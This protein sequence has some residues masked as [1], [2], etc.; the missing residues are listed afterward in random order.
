MPFSV[1][2]NVW[3]SG[4]RKLV[5]EKSPTSVLF[6]PNIKFHSFGFDA[7][8]KYAELAFDGKANDWYF[9]S[10]FK[11][12]LYNTKTIKRSFEIVADNG[13]MLPAMT[14]FSSCIKYLVN[15][16]LEACSKVVTESVE[17][18]GSGL[19]TGSAKN[20]DDKPIGSEDNSDTNRVR[21][22]KRSHFRWVLTVPAI[23][24][25]AAKQ[26]M[27]EAAIKAGIPGDQLLIALEPEV[28]SIYCQSFPI[29]MLPGLKN[30]FVQ[31]QPGDKYLILDAGG[32]TIDVTV[33]KVHHDGTL[34]ELH[35]ASGGDWGGTKVDKAFNDLL[36]NIV[37]NVVMKKVD[38]N[39]KWAYL[40]LFREF[41]VKKRTIT[42]GMAGCIRMTVPFAFSE[43]YKEERRREVK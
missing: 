22:L 2:T 8:D 29:P 36:L 28:A 32:G 35:A 1:Y 5:Y 15:H 21:A 10:R 33:H 34:R 19:A 31:L 7:E 26:F 23:W 4:S 30:D 37:G 14:V 20:M 41:E 13:K 25:D 18:S 27:R 11:M 12:A 38:R 17:K 40:D 9:F 43:T 3:I 24:N 42:P 6:D 39:D 16:L